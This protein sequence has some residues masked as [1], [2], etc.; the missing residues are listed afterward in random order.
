MD[1]VAS[2]VIALIIA[3]G[4]RLN[5]ST[6]ANCTPWNQARSTT[7]TPD[8]RNYLE[9]QNASW[10]ADATFAATTGPCGSFNDQVVK[11]TTAGD[12][13]PGLEAAIAKRIEREILPALQTVYVPAAWGF[14]GTN[15]VLPFAATFASPGPGPGTSDYRGASATF[16][17]LLPFNQTQGCTEAASNPR[18]TTATAGPTALLV[19][20]KYAADSQTGGSGSIQTQSTCNW[21]STTYVCKGE[22]FGPSI[23][24][25]VAV[26]VA[27]VAM[28]LRALDLSKIT[29]TAVDDVG[30]GIGTQTVAC[31]PS[32]ALQSDGS[33]IVTVSTGAMPDIVASGWGTYANYMI[34][35]ERAA[36]GDHGL[37][38]TI[39][40]GTCPSYGCTAWF[41]RNEWYRLLYYAVSPSNAALKVATERSC[42]ALPADCLTLTTGTTPSSKSA[43]LILAGHSLNG[44]ARPSST[45]ADY[46]EFG[47]RTANYEKLPVTRALSSAYADTGGA[48]AYNIAAP[49]A[50]GRPLQFKAVNANT[51]ASTL[52]ASG[53]GAKS[54]VNADGSACRRRRSRQAQ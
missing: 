1:G 16:A 26:R 25:G 34:N 27:N 19:F 7:G 46:L 22:Y 48:N 33:A 37:L 50:T 23:S 11:A 8:A 13:L 52:T 47:N 20:S 10:P 15:P 29:C 30:A 54:L 31:S 36:F 12:I 44:N 38:S 51:G 21:Q 35:I 28:G 42:S 5:V 39:D 53:V 43:L 40:P 6:S 24:V 9:C 45:L 2:D 17:G 18:C 3:P 32:V 41:A 14:A 4:P 49:V